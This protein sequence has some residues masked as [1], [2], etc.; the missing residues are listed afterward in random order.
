VVVNLVGW[1]RNWPKAGS[2]ISL[3]FDSAAIHTGLDQLVVRI[4]FGSYHAG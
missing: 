2:S 3:K 4:D 1:L